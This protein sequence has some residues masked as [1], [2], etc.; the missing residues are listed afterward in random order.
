MQYLQRLEIG[1]KIFLIDDNDQINEIVL[2]YE[3]LKEK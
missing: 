3:H 1:D 2:K